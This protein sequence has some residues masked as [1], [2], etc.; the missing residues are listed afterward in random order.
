ML[1]IAEVGRIR[2][3]KDAGLTVTEIFKKTGYACSTIRRALA[4]VGDT[5]KRKEREA[6]RVA[7][8]R[9]VLEKLA[10]EVKVV[11]GRPLP[12]NS[13]ITKLTAAL[14]KRGIK[15]SRTT[16]H[17]DMSATHDCVVR[18]LRPFDCEN[19]VAKRRALRE[20]YGDTAGELFVFSDEHFVTTNDH[21]TKSQWVRKSLVGEEGELPIPRI[22]KSRFNIPSVM[23]WAAVGVDYKSPLV[24]IDKRKDGD[25]KTLGMDAKRYVRTCLAKLVP[26]MPEGRIFMQDGARCHTAKHTLAY[27]E[28]KGVDLLEGWPPYSPDLNPIENLWHYLDQ[29]IS[30]EA[31]SSL[32]EL[33]RV[34]KSAWEAIPLEVINSFVLSFKGRFDTKIK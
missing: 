5:R 23:I 34:A 6:P 22:R 20:R 14:K 13:S 18:P 12:K 32:A 29:K 15:A 27:L 25:G 31:P 19:S 11:N 7:K 26:T 28:R 10:S 3:L 17:R 1:S 21:T 9:E 4:H 33:K 24:F 8:R 30:E 16:V 2:G